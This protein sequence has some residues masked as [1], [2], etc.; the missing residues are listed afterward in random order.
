[1]R[2]AMHST[3]REGIDVAVGQL[4]AQGQGIL[5]NSVQVTDIGV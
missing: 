1:M 3:A 4:A 5:G 2:E